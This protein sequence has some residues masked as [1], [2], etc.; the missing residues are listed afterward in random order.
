[1][2][3]REKDKKGISRRDFFKVASAAGVGSAAGSLLFSTPGGD[4]ST[5]Q[6]GIGLGVLYRIK[7]ADLSAGSSYSISELIMEPG[8]ETYVM[9]NDEANAIFEGISGQVVL[10]KGPSSPMS[11]SVVI[12]AGT[13]STVL[14]GNYFQLLNTSGTPAVVRQKFEPVWN[15]DRTY[16]KVGETLVPSSDLWFELRESI[17]QQ[18]TGLKYRVLESTETR[19]VLDVRLEPGV[20]SIEE[21]HQD[22][23]HHL[24]VTQGSGIIRIDGSETTLNLNDQITINPGTRYQFYNPN[25]SRW[26]LQLEGDPPWLPDTSFYIVDGQTIPGA[27]VLFGIR[28][29]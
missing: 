25:S 7:E 6:E 8:S 3:S 15:T 12:D 4:P 16:I 9:Y 2:K 13:Q 29:S 23:T 21:Y 18:Q 19:A 1:M 20:T 27:D 10:L 28:V 17:G 5:G 26:E 22:C 24:T 14:A 11:D